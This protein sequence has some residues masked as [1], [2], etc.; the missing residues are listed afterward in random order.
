MDLKLDTT[1]RDLAIEN[2]AFVLVDGLDAIRQELEIALSFFKSEW[3][4]DTR[5]GVPYFEKILGQKPR[6]NVVKEIFR[7][8]IMLVNGVESIFDLNVDFNSSSRICSVSFRAA[9]IEGPLEYTK[10]LILS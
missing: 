8:A 10:E 4:L 1:T 6:L 2:D 7:E 3:F 5:L 9:T